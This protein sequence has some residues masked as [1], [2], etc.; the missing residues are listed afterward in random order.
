MGPTFS[1]KKS[2]NAGLIGYTHL[3]NKIVTKDVV[4]CDGWPQKT[5]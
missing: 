2:N 3:L 5:K 1:L 4:V